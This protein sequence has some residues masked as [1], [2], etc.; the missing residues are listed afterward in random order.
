MSTLLLAY[1]LIET[2]SIIR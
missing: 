2:I 1:G